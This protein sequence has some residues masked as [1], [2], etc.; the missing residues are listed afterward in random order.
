MYQ[1]IMN[2]STHGGCIDTGLVYPYMRDVSILCAS[3]DIWRMYGYLVDA[4]MH[5]ECFD[6]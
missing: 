2:V 3:I 6:P 1:Y 4:S 5:G